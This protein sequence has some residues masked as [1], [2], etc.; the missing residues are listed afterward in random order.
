MAGIVKEEGECKAAML[1][2]EAV[3][4]SSTGEV[5]LLIAVIQEM[6]HS[7]FDIEDH[8]AEHSISPAEPATLVGP[9]DF[10]VKGGGVELTMIEYIV[11]HRE[12]QRSHV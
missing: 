7:C 10:K 2:Y 4:E 6:R 11:F 8:L 9:L 3:D 1:M 12:L 5:E